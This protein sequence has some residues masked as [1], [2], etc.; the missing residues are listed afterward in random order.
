MLIKDLELLDKM[1]EDGQISEESHT[2][3]KETLEIKIQNL[4]QEN[5]ALIQ[6]SFFLESK[7]SSSK[8]DVAIIPTVPGRIK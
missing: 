4:P 6:N 2:K 3:M 1:H 5:C 8:K 7:E